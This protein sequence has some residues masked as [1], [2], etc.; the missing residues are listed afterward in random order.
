MRAP[1]LYGDIVTYGATVAGKDAE[2][3]VV[4]LDITGTN[5][6]GGVATVGKAEVE[7]PRH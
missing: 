3:G 7:L 5:Q 4:S 2:R 6:E 1:G